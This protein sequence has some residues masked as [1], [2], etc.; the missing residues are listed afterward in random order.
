M[1]VLVLVLVLVSS[2]DSW[3]GPPAIWDPYLLGRRS[4]QFIPSDSWDKTPSDFVPSNSWDEAL[5]IFPSDSWDEN[6]SDFVPS[7]SWDETLVIFPGDSWDA[8]DEPSAM[9]SSNF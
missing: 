4:R 9:F 3:I 7:N 2:K 5:V 8:L 1:F 6:P